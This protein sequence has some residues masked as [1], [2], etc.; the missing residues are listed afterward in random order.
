MCGVLNDGNKALQLVRVEFSGATRFSMTSIEAKG[1]AYS[2][3]VKINVCLFANEVGITTPDTFDFGQ[4]IHNFPLSIHIGVQ[5]SK[6][7]LAR[8]VSGKR[9]ERMGQ[10]T[11]NCWWDS[12]TTRDMAA[13]EEG[14]SYPTIAE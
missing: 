12:G 6:N 8:Q 3:F 2:P 10:L 7:V 13:K 4:G 5:K 9:G 1:H 14:V 11:W